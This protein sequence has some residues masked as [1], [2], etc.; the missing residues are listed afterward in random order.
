M[1]SDLREFFEAYGASFRSGPSAVASFYH[2]PC[3]TA[4]MG[5]THLNLTRGDTEAFF[6]KAMEAYRS[7]GQAGG[8]MLSMDSHPMGK[9][10]AIATVRWAYKDIEGKT[11]WEWTFSYNL[12]RS[13][14]GWKILLQTMHDT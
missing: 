1:V 14:G 11:L 7:K 12:Y 5:S 4:R 9:N 13:G 10:S 2:E 6:A 3:I 8:A